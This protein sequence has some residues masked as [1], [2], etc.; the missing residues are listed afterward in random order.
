M[1]LKYQ[2]LI[3]ID[4][5]IDTDAAMNTDS[6]TCIHIGPVYTHI[7]TNTEMKNTNTDEIKPVHQ[8]IFLG[9]TM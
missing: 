4:M 3:N 5:A 1:L 9:Y 8:G 6:H 7:D 2:K